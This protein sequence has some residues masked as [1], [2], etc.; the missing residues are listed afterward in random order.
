[1]VSWPKTNASDRYQEVF[2]GKESWH[3]YVWSSVDDS[4]TDGNIPLSVKINLGLGFELGLGLGLGLLRFVAKTNTR[5]RFLEVFE[6]KETRQ[7]FI[8]SFLWM[9]VKYRKKYYYQLK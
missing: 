8:Q 3:L 4:K 5:D 2:E 1:M 7:P 6:G 9:T